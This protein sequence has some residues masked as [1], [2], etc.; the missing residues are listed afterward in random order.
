MDAD[1]GSEGNY[2][3]LEDQFLDL[4]ALIPY[5]TMLKEQTKKWLTDEKKV[6]NWYY[7]DTN[8]YYIN[9]LD[10]RFNFNAYRQRTDKY[11]QTRDFKEYKA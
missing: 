11:G 7:A 3:F 10:V 5:G 4:T 1:Y 8:D 9:P 6:M 2:R